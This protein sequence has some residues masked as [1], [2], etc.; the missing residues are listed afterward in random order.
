MKRINKFPDG[1]MFYKGVN[2]EDEQMKNQIVTKSIRL[3][4]DLV[5]KIQSKANEENRNFSNM[6][7][8][9]LLKYFSK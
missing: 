1:L 8:T 4:K 9:I 6:A 3:K 2:P 5:D 7:E